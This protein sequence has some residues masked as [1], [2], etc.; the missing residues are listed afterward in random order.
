MKVVHDGR[1]VLV[2]SFTGAPEEP[3]WVRNLLAE[4]GITIRGRDRTVA[5]AA[6]LVMGEER[7]AVWA[8]AVQSYPPYAEHQERADRLLP[9][10][11][12]VPA[13]AR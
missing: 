7:V 9:V 10:F 11:L 13:A 6:R 4:P 2:G 1:H 12:C 5:V 8:T 3:L